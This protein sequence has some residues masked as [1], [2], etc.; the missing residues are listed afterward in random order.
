MVQANHGKDISLPHEI[1]LGIKTRIEDQ[2]RKQ[3]HQVLSLSDENRDQPL[4]FDDLVS[5]YPSLDAVIQY[6]L[7]KQD[8][9]QLSISALDPYAHSK[10]FSISLPLLHEDS[11]SAENTPYT[12][13]LSLADDIGQAAAL[14]LVTHQQLIQLNL[15][16]EGFKIDELVPLT[17]Y[18]LS[19]S[20]QN[21]V[22]L[23]ETVQVPGK[24]SSLFPV[25]STRYAITTDMSVSQLH[26]ELL[27]FWQ[28]LE[29]DVDLTYSRVK[30]ELVL[31]R[32]NN[33]YTPSVVST[34]LGMLVILVIFH[35]FIRR[36]YFH[37]QLEMLANGKRADEWLDTYARADKPWL[38]LG[39]KWQSQLNYWQQIKRESAQL[40]KQAKTLFD[41]GDV[42]SS[43]LFISKA[44]NINTNAPVATK[45]MLAV[46]NFEKDSK[47]LSDKEQWIRNKVAKAMSNYRNNQVFKAL[48]QAYQA[49]ESAKQDKQLKK[50]L[51]A[52]R[53]LINRINNELSP[54][55][56]RISIV[57]TASSQ[58][59]SVGCESCLMIGRENVD[60][61]P[62]DSDTGA[63]LINHKGL[64][65][66]G[67]H[68]KI[69]ASQA[70]FFIEDLGS[71]NGIYVDDRRLEKGLAHKLSSGEQLTLGA[72]SKLAAVCFQVDIGKTQ[73]LLQLNSDNALKNK[74]PLNELANIWPDYVQAIRK[75]ICLMRQH[76][77]LYLDKK[78]GELLLS[79]RV[80]D[81]KKIKKGMPE[82]IAL[83][84]IEL[85]E[86]STISPL[87]SDAVVA[88]N[89]ADVVEV[90]GH[91]L[92]GKMPL[93]LPIELRIADQLISITASPSKVSA[94]M[95]MSIARLLKY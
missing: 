46:E 31:L 21:Q 67:R 90:N 53:K 77:Y 15:S 61:V 44:L 94:E 79:D 2:F 81:D 36:Y 72:E 49:E 24:L 73:G 5:R 12:P 37:H 70:G 45:L 30:A 85:G 66:V 54:E 1:D 32:T 65:R 64:S 84:R 17:T 41:A 57:Q 74:L 76:S 29:I 9:E 95:D 42:T 22:K 89:G 58:E 27:R 47:Q 59:L 82:R 60:F 51:K 40:E 91:K 62:P 68:A 48:R 88:E 4:S 16:L 86:S 63:I 18:L 13:L 35:L 87:F 19:L 7:T 75:N 71:A 28:L 34:T 38:R 26:N 43:K 14:K 39:E 6:S 69:S 55:L 23:I 20:K 8:T 80:V 33:P 50:Q 56:E 83:A 3:L 78:S 10:L 11:S 92:L 52:I 25:V 93:I